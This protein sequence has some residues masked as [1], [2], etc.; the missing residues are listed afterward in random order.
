MS[1]IK[2][3]KEQDKYW[4]K[5]GNAVTHVDYPK[6][7][8][9]VQNIKKFIKKVNDGTGKM[10]DRTFINGVNVTWVDNEGKFQKGTFTTRELRPFEEVSPKVKKPTKA[11]E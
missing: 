4:I 9:R 11:K 10:V 5:T 6:I 3:E 7:K 2:L 1:S 8:M